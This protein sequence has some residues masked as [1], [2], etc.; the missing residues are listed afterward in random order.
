MDREGPVDDGAITV[1]PID[2]QSEQEIGLVAERMRLTLVEVLGKERGE[3]M[4]TLEWLRERVRFH[5]DLAHC[6]GEVFLARDG[7]QTAGHAIVRVEIED[8]LR[9]G[10]FS[11]FY[12]APEY[13][14]RGVGR[15]L[16]DAGEKWMRERSLPEARTYTAEDNA[17]LHAMME[18]L[19]YEIYLRKNE[20]VA[21]RRYL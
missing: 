14:G 3:S 5:L 12:V 17:P 10:L 16:A 1:G 9:F 15:K 13:R 6:D 11:T 18:S 8:G 7:V 4:Y 2:R 19:G 21:F 20:M